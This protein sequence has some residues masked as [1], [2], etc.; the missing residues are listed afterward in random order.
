MPTRTAAISSESQVAANF[1]CP[2][3]KPNWRRSTA[4]IFGPSRTGTGRFVPSWACVPPVDAGH[5]GGDQ[6]GRLTSEL[7]DLV[8]VTSDDRIAVL[9]VQVRN[10][11]H[12]QLPV[13]FRS[14]QR[15][16]CPWAKLDR[17]HEP[18]RPIGSD[19]LSVLGRPEDRLEFFG[20]V[21]EQ[22]EDLVVAAHDRVEDALRFLHAF[23]L[24]LS[25]APN[26]WKPLARHDQLRAGGDACEESIE[27]RKLHAVFRSTIGH[28]ERIEFVEVEVTRA[29][30][31]RA[32]AIPSSFRSDAIAAGFRARPGVSPTSL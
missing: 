25:T 17:L 13:F 19:G 15:L 32:H 7:P 8:C 5:A 23:E 28:Q 21:L 20:G 14:Q 9:L 10:D 18:F 22:T 27:V 6:L 31:R 1:V 16:P 11:R 4:C 26:S 24:G 3:I 12:E 2:C 29:K 30:Q